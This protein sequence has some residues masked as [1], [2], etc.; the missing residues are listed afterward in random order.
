MAI[1]LSSRSCPRNMQET[2][3][4]F[5]VRGVVRDR[6]EDYAAAFVEGPQELKDYCG[7]QL[8]FTKFRGL[9]EQQKRRLNKQQR[10]VLAVQNYAI[11]RKACRA[12]TEITL[13]TDRLRFFLDGTM[14]AASNM[15]GSISW[16]WPRSE[17]PER[18]GVLENLIM[19]NIKDELDKIPGDKKIEVRQTGIQAEAEHLLD[20]AHELMF[21]TLEL[22]KKL[23]SAS[24]PQMIWLYD[25]PEMIQGNKILSDTPFVFDLPHTLRLPSGGSV[26]VDK[27]AAS[28]TFDVNT[29]CCRDTR[30]ASAAERCNN[31]ACKVITCFIYE[32]DIYGQI[33]I[34]FVGKSP[35]E[36]LDA[37]VR[38]ISV[39]LA[40]VSTIKSEA[41]LSFN[42]AL[43][44]RGY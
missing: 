15:V 18:R 28:W 43:I 10:I 35:R 4:V 3:G 29:G 6:R 11:E 33:M 40:R 30:Q 9:P 41:V 24:H 20:D 1:R 26:I 39:K 21:K 25:K 31:E 36:L 32:H 8:L 5:V 38:E 12:T 42:V 19:K 37:R 17:H 44:A 23:R 14:L 13:E 27:T 2:L 7:S 34:D 22:L 16:V